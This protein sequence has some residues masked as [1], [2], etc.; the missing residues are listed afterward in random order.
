MIGKNSQA[1]VE[2]DAYQSFD[3]FESM[4]KDGLK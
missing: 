3:L 4:K 2:S 1:V